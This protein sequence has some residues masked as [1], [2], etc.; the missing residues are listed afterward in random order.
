MRLVG[1]EQLLVKFASMRF[2]YCV[3][4]SRYLLFFIE[5]SKKT[6]PS[7]PV[8]Q[9]LKHLKASTHLLSVSSS[10]SWATRPDPSNSPQLPAPPLPPPY[11]RTHE[12]WSFSS[13]KFLPRI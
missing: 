10:V 2:F 11:T 5:K 9:A 7:Y 4:L 6:F 1:F 13:L 12:H 3:F 8:S